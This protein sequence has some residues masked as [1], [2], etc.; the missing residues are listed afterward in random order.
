MSFGSRAYCPAFFMYGNRLNSA[1][2]YK[3][4]GVCV[5]AGASFSTSN[6]RSLIRFRSSANTILNVSRKPSEP[7]L[8]KLLFT[9]C[10]P[11]LTYA[12]DVLTYSARQ[13]QPM[14]VAL[15][16]CVRRIFGYHRWESVRFL[17]SSFG[18]PSVIDIFAS[19]SRRFFNK[20]PRTGNPTLIRL[21][22]AGYD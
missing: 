11:H 8:M 14:T 13:M 21:A 9:I 19:R 15:N 6:L 16:D 5:V 12:S 22:E 4:L 20:L 7:M 18:Y 1:Q 3:Y 17:R 10:V 2:E